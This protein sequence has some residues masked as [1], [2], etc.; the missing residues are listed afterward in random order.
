MREDAQIIALEALRMRATL[1]TLLDFWRPVEGSDE[2]VDVVDLVRERER[3]CMG[4]LEERGVRMVVE[5]E[6]EALVRGN[7]SRLRL[8]LEQLLNN[9]AQALANEE[10]VERGG[11]L[12]IRVSV[13]QGG[14]TVHLIVSDSGIG[15]REPERV[16]E[17]DGAGIGLSV[18]YGIVHEHAGE[19]HAFNL[20][21]H[22]AGVAVELPAAE[23]AQ[24]KS[25]EVA[26]AVARA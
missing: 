13:V 18:C 26:G 12:A 10:V 15:F 14:E 2:L 8:V 19:I 17:G 24:K 16:F 21:P 4:M 25:G 20:S 1:E 7:R 11:K 22:G 6:G 3:A 23:F 5:A 9:A